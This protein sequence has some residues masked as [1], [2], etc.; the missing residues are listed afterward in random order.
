MNH[1]PGPWKICPRI[2]NEMFAS[3]FGA[4][5]QLIVN[6]GDGGNGIE[7]Q[8]ANAHLIAAAPEMYAALKTFLNAGVFMDCGKLGAT[9]NM[10][11]IKLLEKCEG[12]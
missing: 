5:G 2:H 6:L 7:R 1:T 11:V 8:T 3:V 4:D 10:D 12:K 9:W